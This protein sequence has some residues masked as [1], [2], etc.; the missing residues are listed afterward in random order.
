MHI[1]NN[2][3]GILKLYCL[4]ELDLL[5]SDLAA[6]LKVMPCM[7]GVAPVTCHIMCELCGTRNGGQVS[8]RLILRSASESSFLCFAAVG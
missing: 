3:E 8:R 4:I 2:F 6:T 5:C 1:C 7:V